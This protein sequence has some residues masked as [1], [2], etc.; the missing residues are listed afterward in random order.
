[1]IASEDESLRLERRDAELE[2]L[3]AAFEPNELWIGTSVD[4]PPRVY[5]RLSTEQQGS[6]ATFLLTLVL[7]E[8]YPDCSL[9]LESVQV[10]T[11][12]TASSTLKAAHDAASHLC[13]T[14]QDAAEEAIGSES[15]F[16]V[17]NA[18][19]DWLCDHWPSF[20][21]GSARVPETSATEQFTGTG[22]ASS[23]Y[24]IERRFIFSHHIISKIKRADIMDL[25]NSQLGLTGYMKIGWPGVLLIEGR[26]PSLVQYHSSVAVA[27][28]G[29]TRTR[30]RR[31]GRRT[32]LEKKVRYLCR[33]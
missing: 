32:R 6:R 10:D 1:M 24:V 14:C 18:T 31:I 3:L 19:Q 26:P 17:L 9:R 8:L 16:T 12:Q 30:T 25:A 33:D 21:E 5:R 22:F 23:S 13:Q 15:V 4:E 7:P 2:C 28:L 27:V 11:E 29:R 20:V